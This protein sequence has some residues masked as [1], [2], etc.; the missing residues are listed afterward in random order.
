[1][2]EKTFNHDHL[3]IVIVLEVLAKVRNSGGLKVAPI[4]QTEDGAVLTL[5]NH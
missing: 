2:E 5:T 3:D 1:M 4:L